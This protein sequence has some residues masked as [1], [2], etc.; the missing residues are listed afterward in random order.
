[1]EP[2]ETDGSDGERARGGTVRTVRREIQG[3]EA[4][5]RTDPESVF[6]RWR[7]E[8]PVYVA[9]HVGDRLTDADADVSSPRI[10]EWEVVDVTAAR[11][12]GKDVRTGERRAWTREAIERGLVVGQYATNLSGF[13]AVTVHPIGSWPDGRPEARGI[14]RGRPYLTVVAYGDSGA[15]YGRRYRF[16]TPDDAR[17]VAIRDEDPAVARLPASL[18]D[19]FDS[20][21]RAALDDAGYDVTSDGTEVAA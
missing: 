18:R 3:H 14:Y 2:D 19:L 16:L 21:V 13:A 4:R 5:V 7:P 17:T 1:M 12:V 15:T 11:V 8:R 9:L 20:A 10:T 6:V